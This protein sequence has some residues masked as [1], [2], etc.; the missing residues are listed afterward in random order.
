MKLGF[1]SAILPEYPLEEVLRF[2]AEAE[3]SSIE[4]KCWPPGRVERR[5]AGVTHF[6]MTNLTP[7]AITSTRALTDRHGVAI[8]GLGYDP[9]P[10]SADRVASELAV[11]HLH[12]PI[13]A[14]AELGVGV[15]NS[16]VGCDPARP[17]E[18]NWPRF[19]E[20]WR[21]AG[22]A[23]RGAR[24]P[25]PLGVFLGALANAG[26]EGHVAIEVEDRALEATLKK[27]REALIISRRHLLQHLIG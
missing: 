2:A 27:R 13:E 22:P 24:R 7:A 9:N 3:F 25:N 19:L 23:R 16:F 5:D 10:L 11:A 4:L 26:Y 12:K 20:V 1:G 17:V 6:D 18:A 14:A 8:S 21:P 15:V